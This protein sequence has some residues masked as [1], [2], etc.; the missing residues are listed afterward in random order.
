[1][2]RYLSPLIPINNIYLSV[3]QSHSIFNSNKQDIY[4]YTSPA[5][6]LCSRYHRS[7]AQPIRTRYLSPARSLTCPIAGQSVPS[8]PRTAHTYTPPLRYPLTRPQFTLSNSSMARQR[9]PDPPRIPAYHTI[10]SLNSPPE[11]RIL[12]S[13]NSPPAYHTIMQLNSYPEYHIPRLLDLN[14]TY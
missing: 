1:M 10:M 4:L 5:R 7:R 11:Y 8:I 14:M 6:S 13:L 9:R 12:M 2:A 3:T